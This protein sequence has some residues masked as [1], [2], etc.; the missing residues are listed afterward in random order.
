MKIGK[1]KM[2]A[3]VST[4][5]LTV[6]LLKLGDGFLAFAVIGGVRVTGGRRSTRYEAATS[7]FAVLAGTSGD[8]SAAAIAIE[9]LLAGIS[10]D[11]LPS[12]GSG[13]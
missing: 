4:V 9:M 5:D 11:D 1:N 10:M 7:L 12:L 13:K 2:S 8:N 3:D 6:N